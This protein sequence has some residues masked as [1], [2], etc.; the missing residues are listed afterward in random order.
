[1]DDASFIPKDWTRGCNDVDDDGF[2]PNGER[3]NRAWHFFQNVHATT[4]MLIVVPLCMYD[5]V[6][7][8][9]NA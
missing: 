2:A 8:S 5:I 3:I 7:V 4:I 9:V 1:M 6:C